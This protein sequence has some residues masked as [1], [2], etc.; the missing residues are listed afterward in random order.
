MS[1]I[2]L[3]FRIISGF[4]SEFGTRCTTSGLPARF[5]DLVLFP[6]FNPN[7]EL[8]AKFSI[9]CTRFHKSVRFCGFDPNSELRAS[10]KTRSKIW[11]LGTTSDFR[12]KFR[13]LCQLHH[14][15]RDFRT[16]S[17]FWVLAA[18]GAKLLRFVALYQK[19]IET[20][21]ASPRLENQFKTEP[22][23]PKLASNRFD[24]FC[25]RPPTQLDTQSD[26]LRINL[27]I[28]HGYA[29]VNSLHIYIY[30]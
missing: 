25:A 6:G 28:V 9:L 22:T 15:V 10:L 26:Q 1:R 19:K 27:E 21:P 16:R 14:S 2:F 23:I 29:Q 8:G 18:F 4:R 7:S 30:I 17:S 12:C 11:R 20:H 5:Q 13:T 3:K 24:T